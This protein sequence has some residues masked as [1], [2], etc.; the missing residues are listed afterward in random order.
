MR[1]GWVS[2]LHRDHGVRGIHP[3][4]EIPICDSVPPFLSANIRWLLHDGAS[5]K[6]HLRSPVRSFPPLWFASWLG[7]PLGF[8]L[9]LSTPPLPVTQRE[10]G[11]GVEH[12][13]ES[14]PTKLLLLVLSDFVSHSGLSPSM[15]HH[16]F[17]FAYLL[18]PR[19]LHIR[20][21]RRRCPKPP[22]FPP[23]PVPGQRHRRGEL[24]P[25]W[26][27]GK[28]QGNRRVQR[29]L[30]PLDREQVRASCR[31]DLLTERTLAIARVPGDHPPPQRHAGKQ[32][33]GCGQFSLR[34]P[35]VHPPF[36]PPRGPHRPHMP[37][38]VAPPVTPRHES[39]ATPC[40]PPQS[41]VRSRDAR[42]PNR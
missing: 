7:S 17:P 42:M 37:P 24:L 27:F 35:V 10:V 34:A 38:P 3:R 36:A 18:H 29:G 13:P 25:R 6:I 40:R 15:R 5:S 33:G 2:S 16:A 14:K 20:I 31:H 19:P 9:S 1:P 4:S 21:Q 28:K 12:S 23:L 32:A 39:R 41:P 8:S 22:F 30:V 11:T 26:R